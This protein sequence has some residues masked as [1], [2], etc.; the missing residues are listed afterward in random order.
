MFEFFFSTVIGQKFIEVRD[1]LA[2]VE[3]GSIDARLIFYL[4]IFMGIL[5]LWEGMRQV[6]SRR[7]NQQEAT[8]RRMKLIKSGKSVEE[9]LSILKPEPKKG[10]FSNLPFVGDLRQTLLSAGM[11]MGPSTFVFGCLVGFVL[12]SVVAIAFTTVQMALVIGF[13]LFIFLPIVLVRNSA[14]R[15]L[16]KLVK[17]LP[18]ALDL[19]ARGLK[20]GHPLNT[21]LA[22]VANEMPDP[23][24]SQFGIVVDQVSYG[25]ELTDAINEFADRVDQEDARYLAAS[26]ALQHGTGGDLARVL[27]TLG[28]V[29]RARIIMRRK[30]KAVSAEGR[31]SAVVLSIIP[32]VIFGFV[33]ISNPSYYGDVS[34]DPL[35]M[36]VAALVTFFVVANAL[37]LRKLVNFRI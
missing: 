31:M 36:P 15:R 22:S 3:I 21:T 10:I 34:D 5:L 23:I 29:I 37:A 19:M 4:G 1:S 30:I 6:L 16:D 25:E 35:A 18:D 33:M 9:V 26:I 7:E 2:G 8:S 17:Q 14:E 13:S 28:K 20:V 11:T 12:T 32:V 24:G 27:S